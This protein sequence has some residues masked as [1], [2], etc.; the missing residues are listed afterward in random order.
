M[1]LRLATS[2]KRVRAADTT[3]LLVFPV[4]ALLA[5]NQLSSQQPNTHPVAS[6]RWGGAG[7]HTPEGAKYRVLQG[8]VQDGNGK[9]IKGAMVYLKDGRTSTM[10]SVTTDEDGT[11][12]FVQLSQNTDYQLW[13]QVDQKK[14]T[15]KTISSF[16]NKNEITMV[17]KVE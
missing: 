16:D 7:D 6:I 14:S 4:A 12:R 11:Y 15:F 5:G 1:N 3:K 9:A 8:K 2:L 10:R 17:L 13:A